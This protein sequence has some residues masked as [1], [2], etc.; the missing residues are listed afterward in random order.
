LTGL[1]IYGLILGA[2][3]IAAP[4]EV[5]DGS[6]GYF[7]LVIG[8]I[9]IW[10]YGWAAI[11]LVRA[12]IYRHIVFP[13]WRAKAEAL[14]E[15]GRPSHVY[16]LVTSFRIAVDTTRDVYAS[17]IAEAVR[18]DAPATIIAS[19]VEM[20]DQRLIKE[21]FV[22]ANPPPHIKL[23]FVRIGGTGKRDALA[24]GFRAIS[25][26]RPPAG[27]V[28][29]VIDGDTILEPGLLE[30]SMPF[31]KLFPK[32]DALTTDEI[33]DVVG[34]RI[35]RE[36]YSMRFAQRQI[37]MC[38]VGLS[39]RV[40][41]LT[42]RMSAFRAEV[43][44]DPE[45]I[46]GVEAD[47]IHHWRL[48]RVKMLTG[49]DKSSW[50]H[51]LRSGAEMLYLPDVRIRTIEH[52][53]HPSF[54]A[55]SAALMVRWFGN[56][57]RTNSRAI[58]V[59]PRRIGLFPWWCIIDQRVSMWTSLVG[60]VAAI[61]VALTLDPFALPLYL[62]WVALTR[63]M[64]TLLLLTV[65]SEVSWYYPFLLYYNQI[66]GSLVKTYIFFRLDRQKWTRQKTK[67][68]FGGTGWAKFAHDMSSAYVHVLSIGLFLVALTT[69]VGALPLLTPDD[70]KV[71]WLP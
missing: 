28:A 66:F 15:A 63:Y 29:C 46:A 3:L 11:H 30:K 35:F 56:M 25:T 53:P 44:T 14:G 58:A 51:I 52:P 8:V 59:G 5:Y 10:R 16:L 64:Q 50:F 7:L 70:L 45:F 41:T 69:V 6:S 61:T 57:L 54:F 38:S 24:F 36:W 62:L 13:R 2:V 47:Y 1:V 21:L 23:V 17:V 42:G 37:L 67:S 65:R 39:R 68:E 33:C 27:S 60:P 19:I 26:D 20:A 18:Y 32:A 48:G 12:L 43:V 71:F 55:S 31:F 49:D 22:A 34:A 4:R 9:G 40:L